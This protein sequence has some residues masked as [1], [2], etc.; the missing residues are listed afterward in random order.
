[1]TDS[2]PAR[3]LAPLALVVFLL[4][5]IVIV[6]SSGG[7]SPARTGASQSG[8]EGAHKGASPPRH[9]TVKGSEASLAVI[10]EKNGVSLNRLIELNPR[11]DPQALAP[12]QRIRLRR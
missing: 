6:A 12:G 7:A 1:M 3:Y 9:Y 5:V 2:S 10:A 8:T 11:L 4:A